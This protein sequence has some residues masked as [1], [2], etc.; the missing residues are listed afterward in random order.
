MLFVQISVASSAVVSKKLRAG[1]YAFDW[2]GTD[3][4]G[5]RVASGVYF[6][7]L[8]T[9]ARTATRKMVLLR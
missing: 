8:T 9:D 3:N 7:R 1:P 4:H 6:Y 5:G 2:D